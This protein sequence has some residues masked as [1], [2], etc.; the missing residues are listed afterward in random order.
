MT[1]TPA[2]PG[3]VTLG[4][5]YRA[6]MDL[7]GSMSAYVLHAVYEADQKSQAK[8][9]ADLAQ[10]VADEKDA[11]EK[12]KSAQGVWVRWGITLFASG[13]IANIASIIVNT[14]GR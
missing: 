10:L 13:T 8:Q 12:D 6:V 14:Q 4:E 1:T 5:V 3:E 9:V 11:R 2:A 7:K